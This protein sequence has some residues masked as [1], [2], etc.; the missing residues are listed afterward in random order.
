LPRPTF[1]NPYSLARVSTG[2][3]PDAV[4]QFLSCQR[5]D[6]VASHDLEDIVAVLD[7]RPEIVAD[8]ATASDD[9][10]STS[11][12]KSIL[13]S[14]IR[15]SSRPSAASFSLTRPTRRGVAS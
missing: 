15:I 12:P 8:I 10:A 1:D 4:V 9:D 5:D 2:S 14:T 11:V 3:R 6:V 7:G 13:C